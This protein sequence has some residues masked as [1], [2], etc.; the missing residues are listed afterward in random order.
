MCWDVVDLFITMLWEV[1]GYFLSGVC[2]KLWS[3][4]V[5]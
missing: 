5:I 4:D 2:L 1:A 3:L